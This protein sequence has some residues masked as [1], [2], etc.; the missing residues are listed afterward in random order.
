MAGLAEMRARLQGLRDENDRQRQQ[1][2]QRVELERGAD[3]DLT[4]SE[5]A[6]FRQLTQIVDDFDGRIKDLD[7]EIR[8]SGRDD[9]DTMA[10]ACGDEQADGRGPAA[11]RRWP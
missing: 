6:E 11:A 5:T 4:A 2:V 10:A 9:P 8:R 1:L 3:A 7:E